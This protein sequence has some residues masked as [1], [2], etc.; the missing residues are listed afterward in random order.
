M[1]IY[2]ENDEQGEAEQSKIPQPNHIIYM[3]KSLLHVKKAAAVIWSDSKVAP[4]ESRHAMSTRNKLP[5]H[6]CNMVSA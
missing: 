3:K 5:S 2:E 1:T 4:E 6:I